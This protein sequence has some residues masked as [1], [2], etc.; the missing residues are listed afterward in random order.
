MINQQLPRAKRSHGPGSPSLL[1]SAANIPQQE[2]K[3]IHVML[4]SA[5]VVR[6]RPRARTPS[7]LERGCW[8]LDTGK[9]TALASARSLGAQLH[10]CQQ[11]WPAPRRRC[12]GTLLRRQLLGLSLPDC[13]PVTQGSPASPFAI[14]ALRG[15]QAGYAAGPQAL[16]VASANIGFTVT[17][18]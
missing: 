6:S 7:C 18:F 17:T 10:S 4:L 15:A 14:P 13:Q 5:K 16:P 1:L 12:S 8:S 3:T 2:K 11:R 9:C